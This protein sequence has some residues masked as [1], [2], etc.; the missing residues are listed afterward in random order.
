MS[1]FKTLD[2]IQIKYIQWYSI[3]TIGIAIAILIISLIVCIQLIRRFIL[4]TNDNIKQILTTDV[5][6]VH[7]KQKIICKREKKI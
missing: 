5:I 1:C 2:T 6:T 7:K 3:A 4:I